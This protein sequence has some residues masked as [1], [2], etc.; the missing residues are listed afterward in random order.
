MSQGEA[1]FCYAEHGVD[2]I[3]GG[4]SLGPHELLG[5]HHTTVSAHLELGMWKWEEV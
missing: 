5:T 4:G 1:G 3:S 2:G